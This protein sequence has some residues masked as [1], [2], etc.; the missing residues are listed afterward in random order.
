MEKKVNLN[1]KAYA[2]IARIMAAFAVVLLHVSGARLVRVDI[3]S[4]K[5][6]WAAAFDCAMR[7]SVPV[8]VMLSGMLFL[9]K[10]KA[11]DIK[12]LYSK[13]ILR[14][15]TA[16][17]FWSFVY[18][19]YNAFLSARSV[20]SALPMALK[21]IHNGAMHLWFV[22]VIIGLYIALPFIKRMCE[23]L[24]KREAEGFILLSIL[25][26]LLPKTLSA[27][28]MCK[29]LAEYINK[30]E[31]TYAAGYVGMFVAGWYIDSFERKKC[32]RVISYILG[33]LGFVFM[34]TATVYYSIER[35]SVVDEFMS[36]K[37]IS[38][39]LMAFA[40][41]DGCKALFKDKEYSR[42]TKAYL[43][44]FS[45]CTFGVY[46]VHELVLNLSSGKGLFLFE[47]MPYIGIP[48]E[49]VVIFLISFAFTK[50]VTLLPFG[51][52]I[53]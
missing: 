1:Y 48:L 33:T 3:G 23:N 6:T 43:K 39:F 26:T 32:E 42:N 52:Y 7:W 41:V 22:F 46:L 8:F 15:V 9:N 44:L 20:A 49:A 29:P 28:E 51:K 34:F 14:L 53:S 21:N 50:F 30:F 37:S 10:E 27:F 36:F 16:F 13:N 47:S 45:N 18:N 35:G 40:F 5:F 19:F 11:L 31:I 4:M 2:D 24:T 38:A 17:L 25:V 12:R